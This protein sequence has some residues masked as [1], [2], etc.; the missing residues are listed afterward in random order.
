MG[1]LNSNLQPRL[2]LLRTAL[3]RRFVW[4]DVVEMARQYGMDYTDLKADEEP[5]GFARDYLGIGRGD[6]PDEVS[7]P[8]APPESFTPAG[9]PFS[10]NS[11]PAVARFLGE[12]AYLRRCSAVIELG[13]FV[14][15]ATAHIARSL[16][17]RGAGQVFAVDMSETYL[18]AMAENLQ[19]HGLGGHVTP[20]RGG[21]LDAS[22]LKALPARADMIFLDTSHAYPATLRE[23]EAYFP[24]LV[25]DGCLVLH[26][27]INAPGVRRSLAELGS[28]YRVMTFATE[29]GNGITVLRKR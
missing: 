25:P 15:W 26:D 24:R 23:I 28:G 13:C 12:L 19:R 4:H 18:R 8:I 9:A 16:A 6:V 11:E 17:L 21:S 5:I 14:G 20:V 2:R 7:R 10:F 27:S 3:F 29:C 22:T 1:F